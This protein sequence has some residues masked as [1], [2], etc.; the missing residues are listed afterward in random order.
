[1]TMKDIEPLH[2]IDVVPCVMCL[3]FSGSVLTG[4]ALQYSC[5]S[6]DFYEIGVFC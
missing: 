2:G 4:L 6:S 5:S 3:D 1:M